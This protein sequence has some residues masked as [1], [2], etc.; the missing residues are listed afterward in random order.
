VTRFESTGTRTAATLAVIAVALAA[1]C[2]GSGDEAAPTE[3]QTTATETQTTETT[4]E[5]TTQTTT[6]A[7]PKPK[8]P[9]A[10]MRIVV[11]G[12]AVSGGIRRVTV[13]KGEKV[14]IVTVS[15]VRDHIH[16]HGY[17][18][19]VDVGPGLPGRIVLV[20]TIPGRFEVELEDRGL[21]VGELEVRP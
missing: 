10:T 19:M 21:Q 2:G 13:K 11:K 14:R 18:R 1:G 16:L 7:K 4:T 6:E 5:S 3:T 8:P 15:D 20:A 17:D 12:G 9:V